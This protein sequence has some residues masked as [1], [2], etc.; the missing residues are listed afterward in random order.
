MGQFEVV[1]DGFPELTLAGDGVA[2]GGDL[3]GVGE[4]GTGGGEVEAAERFGDAGTL[5]AEGFG[6]GS[7]GEDATDGE[8][9]EAVDLSKGR[10]TTTLAPARVRLAAVRERK[11]RVYSR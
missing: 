8:A 2:C 7:G 3:D 9:G 11:S 1:D 4:G 5:F 10:K 6:E